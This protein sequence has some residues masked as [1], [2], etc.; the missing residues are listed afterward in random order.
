[1]NTQTEANALPQTAVFRRSGEARLWQAVLNR[2]ARFDGA[3]VYAVQTTGI[4]CRPSC[5]S[6]KPARRNVDFYP[7]PEVAERAGFRPCRRCRPDKAESGDPQVEQAREICR[8]IE[9]HLDAPLTLE[10]LGEQFYLSPYHLQ[11][12]FKEI[13]GISPQQYAEACR[14]GRVKAA[15]R[16]GGDISGATYEAGFGSLS[17]LYDKADA[18][19]GMTPL[20]YQQNGEGVT[21]RYTVAASPLGRLLVAATE[22]GICAVK[23][24]SSDRALEEAL[25]AEFSQAE[26]RRDDPALGPWIEK[27]LRHL[28]GHLPH[29]DLPLDVRA[30]AFQKRVWQELQTIPYGETRSYGQVAQAIGQPKASRAVARACAANPAALVVPCHR[31]VRQD[32]QPGGYRWGVE[33]KEK[34][35]Q[36]EA[37]GRKRSKE[38]AS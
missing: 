13:V 16:Q 11:R 21:I 24:G 8:Y 12:T 2:D 27:I 5:P 34:L 31:V 29:L 6:R 17:R 4:Y 10:A 30:T 18:Q 37:A 38:G 7:L 1:M 20:T 14:I 19:F 28:D 36:M 32:G 35:L 23:I 22:R 33:R 9:A 26:I 25:G 15:L 3:F